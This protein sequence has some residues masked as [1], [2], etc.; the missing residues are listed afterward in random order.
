[1]TF[2]VSGCGEANRKKG[3]EKKYKS[4]K[5]DRKDSKTETRRLVACASTGAGSGPEASG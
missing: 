2:F 5:S 4:K 3:G 1:M